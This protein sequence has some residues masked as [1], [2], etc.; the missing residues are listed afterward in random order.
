MSHV[1]SLVNKE[2]DTVYIMSYMHDANVHIFFHISV[3]G[4]FFHKMQKL[5]LFHCLE[6]ELFAVRSVN[7]C[8]NYFLVLS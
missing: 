1:A 2:L 3:I 5:D 8:V 6:N 4:F 7:T